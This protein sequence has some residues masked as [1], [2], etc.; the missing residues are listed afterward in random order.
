MIAPV[1]IARLGLGG[2]PLPDISRRQTVRCAAAHQSG[3]RIKF[4]GT[5]CN[6]FL[7]IVVPP[8][9]PLVANPSAY[10][11]KFVDRCYQTP[12][13]FMEAQGSSGGNGSPL[14]SSSME[15]LSGVRINAM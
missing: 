7:Q 5:P 3:G 2:E 8:G 10:N 13:F 12:V 11:M 4:C 1:L 15:M 9:N 14:C 6:I